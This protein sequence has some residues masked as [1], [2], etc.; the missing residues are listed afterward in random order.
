[1]FVLHGGL[2]WDHTYLRSGVDPLGDTLA[3][4]YFDLLGNG[5]SA[6]PEDW[7]GVDHAT[8]V[9]QI[10]DQRVRSGHDR[11]FLFG[12]SY[13]GFLAM[14]YALR[15]PDRVLGLVLCA[16]LSDLSGV[17]A[18]LERARQRAPA[19]LYETLV[20]GLSRPCVEDE[21]LAQLTRTILPLYFA[22]PPAAAL[23]AP[24]EQ[25]RFRAR[26][27]DRAMFH[28]LPGY[29]VTDRLTDVA[30]P[31]LVMA[32]RDDWLAPPAEGAERIGAALPDATVAIFEQSGHFPF[33]EEPAAFL[34]TVRDWIEAQAS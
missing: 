10:E 21:A 5:R 25:I 33:L 23:L 7:D 34:R 28:C 30:V 1:M 9:E 14:E 11:I 8:W 22:R 29:D 18:A 3:L 15:H 12:H 31:A 24:F 6:D 13:G 26:A 32:G 20:Q 2:G 27:Y 19:A 17:P 4:R 16:T